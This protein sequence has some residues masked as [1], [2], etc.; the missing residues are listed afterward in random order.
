M[1]SGSKLPSSYQ[2][3]SLIPRSSTN[4][5]IL[6]SPVNPFMGSESPPSS[7]TSGRLSPGSVTFQPPQLAADSDDDSVARPFIAAEPSPGPLPPKMSAPPTQTG[8]AENYYPLLSPKKSTSVRPS[9]SRSLSA[10]RSRITAEPKAEREIFRYPEVPRN[11]GEQ[12]LR[13]KRD[14]LNQLFTGLEYKLL[15]V[16]SIVDDKGKKIHYAAVTTPK[17]Y[18]SFVSL[19]ERESYFTDETWKFQEKIDVGEALP[20]SIRTSCIQGEIDGII[21]MNELSICVTKP[22]GESQ[23]IVTNK[24]SVDGNEVSTRQLDSY[25]L[26]PL[27]S[28]HTVMENPRKAEDTIFQA[29]RKI[30]QSNQALISELE[31]TA[32]AE[33]AKMRDLLDTLNE[34]QERYHEERDSV[35]QKWNT[36]GA[37]TNFS[38]MDKIIAETQEHNLRQYKHLGKRLHKI[39]TNLESFI[40]KINNSTEDLVHL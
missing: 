25:C 12:L 15:G 16:L 35:V 29:I 23:N 33:F 8:N 38:T 40:Q 10:P 4:S 7:V 18:Y 31:S 21:H 26:S 28:V 20:E 6:K 9:S 1:S 39:N 17:G 5:G 24:F 34:T 36:N 32:L 19:Q 27:L 14:Q 30:R 22:D 11:W 2:A 13:Q 3:P 37:H